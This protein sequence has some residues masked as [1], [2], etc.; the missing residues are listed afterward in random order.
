MSM[1]KGVNETFEQELTWTVDN[2]IEVPSGHVT[3][4]E[5]VI[6]E[7]EFDGEFTTK[8]TFQGKVI[9]VYETKQHDFVDAV[10]RD[11][12]AFLTPD[13]GFTKDKAGRPVFITKGKCRCRFGI[14]QNVLLKQSQLPLLETQAD[15]DL[16]QSPPLEATENGL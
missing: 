4:A 12:T 13:K 8:T 14:E 15:E 1:E 10:Q 2:E 9:V 11:V 16:S 6:K 7:D 5:L 3:T